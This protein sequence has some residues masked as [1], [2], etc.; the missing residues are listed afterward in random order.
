[1]IMLKGKNRER[2]GSA[3][4]GRGRFLARFSALL[5]LA[6]R[7]ESCRRCGRGTLPR[8]QRH[9]RLHA[10]GC[11]GSC[12][13]LPFVAAAVG[14]CRECGVCLSLSAAVV[15][16]GAR[17]GSRPRVA[18]SAP[19]GRCAPCFAAHGS[20]RPRSRH[21]LAGLVSGCAA[22]LCV[23]GLVSRAPPR[24]SRPMP[25]AT[26]I[27]VACSS[28]GSLWALRAL[29]VVAGWSP[30]SRRGVSAV[31]CVSGVRLC[32]VRVGAGALSSTHHPPPCAPTPAAAWSCGR[33][34]P[35]S[36]LV[37]SA[38]SDLH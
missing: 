9:A 15:P 2:V 32:S 16:S 37:G 25:I 4:G 5:P 36:R 29:W 20:A 8:Q 7:A 3:R 1:M 19:V 35:R 10:C 18:R 33:V 6:R 34:G 12:R 28:S 38:R 26:H 13:L 14:L 21:R 30:R 27:V 11:V 31:L 17:G 24:P 22:V 23:S